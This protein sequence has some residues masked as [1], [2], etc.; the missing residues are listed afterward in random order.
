MSQKVNKIRQ[1]QSSCSIIRMMSQLIVSLY[2]SASA[3]TIR[4]AIYNY[5]TSAHQSALSHTYFVI[6]YLLICLV[7]A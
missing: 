3:S 1:D 5:D 7:I 6:L 4:Q 2:D